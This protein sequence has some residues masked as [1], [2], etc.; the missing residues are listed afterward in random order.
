MMVIST[1][2]A[3]IAEINTT[4]ESRITVEVASIFVAQSAIQVIEKTLCQKRNTLGL[5]K[6]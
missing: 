3:I 4:H 5:K 1:E 2:C 6:V